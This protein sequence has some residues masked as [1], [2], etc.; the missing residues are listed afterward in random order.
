MQELEY[1][2]LDVIE[3]TSTR[4]RMSVIVRFN[5]KLILYCKGADSVI[6]QRV[7]SLQSYFQSNLESFAGKGLR[8]LA[9]AKRELTEEEYLAFKKSKWST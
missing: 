8:T 6:F 3:F 7:E 9:V 2:L 1:T 5:D 4:K